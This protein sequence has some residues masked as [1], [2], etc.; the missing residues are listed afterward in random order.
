VSVLTQVNGPRLTG[1]PNWRAATEWSRGR[2]LEWS[3]AR[4]GLEARARVGPGWMVE[5]FSI[6]TTGPQHMLLAH[7]RAWSGGGG[8]GL[9]AGGPGFAEVLPARYGPRETTASAR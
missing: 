4:P 3:V 7:P 1:T 5:R 8:G 9:V 6:A 2:L